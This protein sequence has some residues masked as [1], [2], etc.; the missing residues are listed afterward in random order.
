[1]FVIKKH[2]IMFFVD[3]L[4]RYFFRNRLNRI[5]KLRNSALEDQQKWFLYLVQVLRRT[6]YGGEF[7]AGRI[8]DVNSFQH[9]IPVRSYDEM[10]SYIDLC[11]TGVRNV[12]WPGRIRWYARSSGTTSDRSKYIP[13]TSDSLYH[14][15]YRGGAD[16]FTAYFRHHP[17]TRIFRGKTV[18]IGG[19]LYASD[20]KN[21]LIGD[22]SAILMKNLPVWAR[23]YR[24]PALSIALMS[25]WEK[26]IDTIARKILR[27][28]VVHIAGVPS[29]TLLLLEKVIEVAQVSALD[30]VW[31]N[32]EV[33]FHGG[34]QFD[35]YRERFLSLF[36]GKVPRL[37]ETYNA[38][39][40]F[41][42]IE[43]EPGSGELLL[44][45]DH[46]VFYEF[47]PFETF[48]EGEPFPVAYD[49]A[50]V[51]TGVNYVLVITTNGGLWRYVIGDTIMFSKIRP[52]R[53]RITGRTKLYINLAGEEVMLDNIEAAMSAA[54]EK[55]GA[56][57]N[58][59]TVCPWQKNEE[60]R[61][62]W[63]VEFIK[64]PADINVFLNIL[65]QQLQRL[66]SD[67]EAKRFQDLV[68][69][70][71]LLSVVKQQTFYRWMK[72]KG[73]LGGQHKVPRILQ[74]EKVAQEIL[75]IAGL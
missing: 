14:C 75:H 24:E 18:A 51:E 74:S 39:E 11:M 5:E 16:L 32:F 64:T 36:S 47:I 29:W 17:E 28:D 1:M 19:S 53:F 56:V 61:H 73:K 3:Y 31:K 71:P 43:D 69:K 58:E 20:N 4:L 44:L 46:G 7:G 67:Y 50:K 40:G 8:R 9:T 48:R 42:G 52:Y 59:Y 37:M 57:V 68:L 35:P 27:E 2:Q 23:W 6:R 38:S 66:N 10:K 41:F 45:T 62:H 13:V 22:L 34:V 55:T 12:L 30:Q 65:D 26:K 54:C 33:Y 49:L 15:H 60:L 72:Q 70:P 63:I 21:I 25:D